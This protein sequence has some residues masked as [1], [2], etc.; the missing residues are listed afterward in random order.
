MKPGKASQIQLCAKPA[1]VRER[2]VTG[3]S[4]FHVKERGNRMREEQEIRKARRIVTKQIEEFEKALSTEQRLLLSGMSVALQWVCGDGGVT[5]QRLY[6]GE[7]I[8]IGKGMNDVGERAQD[9]FKG[10]RLGK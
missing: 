1:E 3:T 9:F 4:V 5:L 7:P 2:A 10:G 6:D 8:Q